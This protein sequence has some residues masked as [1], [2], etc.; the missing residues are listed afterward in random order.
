MTYRT[1]QLDADNRP[2]PKTELYCVRCHKDIKPGQPHLYVHIEDSSF[3]AVVHPK[4]TPDF[5]ASEAARGDMGWF[6]IGMDCARK[7]GIEFCSP[8]T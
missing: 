8:L 5:E 7:I 6:P 1:A 3:A 4:D 2:T